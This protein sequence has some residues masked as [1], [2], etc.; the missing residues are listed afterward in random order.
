MATRRRTSSRA[1]AAGRP[2]SG[3]PAGPTRASA[4]PRPFPV[5]RYRALASSEAMST[6]DISGPLF[7]ALSPSARLQWSLANRL[8]A[9]MDANGSLEFALI[10][11][12]LDMPSGPP[13]CR[14]Q[15]RARRP[16]ASAYSSWPT[17]TASDY[18]TAY[19][20]PAKKKARGWGLDLGEVAML[21]AWATPAAR[22]WKDTPGMATSATNPDGSIRD[23]TD[24]LPRQAHL[25]HSTSG[26]TST[27][28]ISPTARTGALSPAHS[29][30]LMGYPSAWDACAP[31]GTPSSRR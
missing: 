24:Q 30:W 8:R 17:P 9:R 5:S 18:F 27:S 11:R 31:T 2:R 1:S 21:T 22:D 15:A 14:L 26:A 28:P 23:R 7:S 20:Q 4:G 12:D 6:N 3:S 29:R 25:V 10:W 16:S 13:V 19:N